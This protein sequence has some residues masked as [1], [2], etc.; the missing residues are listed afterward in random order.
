MNPP[1]DKSRDILDQVLPRSVKSHI[2][3]RLIAAT[4]VSPEQL[5]RDF[6]ADAGLNPDVFEDAVTKGVDHYEKIER[7]IEVELGEA[8]YEEYTGGPGIMPRTQLSLLYALIRTC[9]P[10]VVV[11]TGVAQGSSTATILQAMDDNDR[12]HLYSI[13]LPRLAEETEFEYRDGDFPLEGFDAA[14]VPA[15]KEP[16]WLVDDKLA[17]RWTLHIGRSTEHLYDVMKNRRVDLFVHDSEHTYKNMLWELSIAAPELA[18]DGWLW[19]DDADWN[20]AADHFANGVEW[21]LYEI[22]R[23]AIIQANGSFDG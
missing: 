22:G 5:G 2:P 12:G 19:V 13:D 20:D 1:L 7:A 9:E 4:K 8:Y 17:G 23:S 11:E 16:G 14:V 15:D 6:A 18:N 3:E 10:D 21:S